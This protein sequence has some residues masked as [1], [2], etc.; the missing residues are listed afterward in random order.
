MGH[1]AVS[2]LAYAHPGGELLFAG[3]SFRI[4]A[5]AHV[6]LVGANGVG[7]STLLKILAGVLVPDEGEAGLGGRVGYMPQDVGIDGEP[8][9]VR[10]LLLSLAAASVRRAGESVLAH[11]GQLA[12]GDHEAGMQLGAANADWSALGGY[13]REGQWDVGCRRIVGA[14]FD[15]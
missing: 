9:S 8:R 1:V 13:E 10:E 5:G 2:N 11:E 15:A 14:P 7:K 4:S 3:V 6:G 12:A